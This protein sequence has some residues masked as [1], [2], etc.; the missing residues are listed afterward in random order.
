MSIYLSLSLSLCVYAQMYIDLL[1][2]H[3]HSYYLIFM[4]AKRWKA[5][6]SWNCNADYDSCKYWSIAKCSSTTDTYHNDHQWSTHWLPIG[7]MYGIYAN[8]SGILM[9]N[10]TIYGI[11]GSYGLLHVQYH[12]ICSIS[13]I[14]LET[15]SWSRSNTRPRSEK[16]NTLL[17]VIPTMAFNSSH[18]TIYLVYL[19]G[20][21]IWHS[22][23]VQAG[24]CK[25]SRRKWWLSICCIWANSS[26]L[27]RCFRCLFYTERE[28][29]D[30]RKSPQQRGGKW[31]GLWRETSRVSS[32]LVVIESKGMCRGKAT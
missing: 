16:K 32:T 18:L 22:T 25:L 13:K 14:S 21:S 28:Q 20:I 23:T 17:R 7:S 1:Y 4:N 19:S 15:G 5:S 12:Q 8:I 26:M 24:I 27:N 10:V 2:W 9:V 29:N 11:H 6:H 3:W 30:K 31:S